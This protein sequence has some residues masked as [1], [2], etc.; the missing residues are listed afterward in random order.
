MSRFSILLREP[1]VQ[2]DVLLERMPPLDIDTARMLRKENELN[3]SE[4]SNESN[5]STDSD[6]SSDLPASPASNNVEDLLG[7]LDS[8]S[9]SLFTILIHRVFSRTQT[10]GHE[11]GNF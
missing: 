7:L 11:R 6:S 5:T 2:L 10:I 1:D 4:D 8:R 3:D 9:L